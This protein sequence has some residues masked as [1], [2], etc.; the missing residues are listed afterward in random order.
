M[1]Y[2]SDVTNPLVK[3]LR[4][5]AA[6]P[7]HQ[8]AG[9]AA[10]FDFWRSEVE[11]RRKLIETYRQRFRRLRDAEQAYG[12]AHGFNP[13][14]QDEWGVPEDSAPPL[15]ASTKDSE[16]QQMLRDLDS[17]FEAWCRRLEREG[18]LPDDSAEQKH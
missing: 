5:F 4:H 12:Q 6:L 17:A 13:Q 11:H 14:P 8:L 18:L 1:S 10:N 15:R 7:A 2:L 16:R 9:H 3:S